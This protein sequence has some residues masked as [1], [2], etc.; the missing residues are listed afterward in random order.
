MDRNAIFARALRAAP[1]LPGGLKDHADAATGLEEHV[2]DA[3][4]L[5]FLDEQI[6]ADA[7]GPEWTARLLRRRAALAPYAGVPLLR[8]GVIA[9]KVRFTVEVDPAIPAVVHWEEYEI[10]G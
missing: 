5:G 7:R 1:D 9:G 10:P 3:T 2:F 4:Y 6:Q 8:G